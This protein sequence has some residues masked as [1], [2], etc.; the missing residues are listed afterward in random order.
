MASGVAV[1]PADGMVFD[2]EYANDTHPTA[3]VPV[4][5]VPVDERAGPA[6]WELAFY[7]SPIRYRVERP[8]HRMI[9][10]S[11]AAVYYRLSEHSGLC[12]AKLAR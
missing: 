9:A 11:V 1:V 12:P 5:P 4:E 2:I 7:H 10:T 3:V 6:G 8:T